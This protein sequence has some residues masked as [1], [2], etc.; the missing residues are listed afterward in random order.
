[1]R[2]SLRGL[3]HEQ[4]HRILQ[5]V[6][7]ALLAPT[8]LVWRESVVWLVF[9]SWYANEVGHWSGAEAARGGGHCAGCR[10]TPGT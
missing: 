2:A 5:F 3:S 7:L 6:W 1:M 8:V 4:R 9:M 10:C